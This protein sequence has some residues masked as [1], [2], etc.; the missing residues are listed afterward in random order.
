LRPVE[1]DDW[2]AFYAWDQDDEAS[3][4]A[5]RIDFPRSRAA[6]R[7]WAEQAATERPSGNAFRW[8]IIDADGAFAGSINTHT[9]D[10]RVGSFGIGIGV[11]PRAQG[12]CHA[13]EAIRLVL[14]RYMRQV[15]ARPWQATA[16]LLQP[17]L[18]NIFVFYVPPIAIAHLLGLLATNHEPSWNEL[19][20]PVLLLAG[21]W[22]GGEALWRI[23][24]YIISRF[25]C[26]GIAALQ[27]EAMDELY[28]KDVGF[29]HNNF[30]NLRRSKRSNNKLCRVS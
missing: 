12:Q 14:R 28:E 17:G 19:A 6:V 24:H 30:A 22:L 4:M 2:P 25:E 3:R 11:V 8:V 15:R 7:Q 16:S 10:P 18:G 9:C 29:F 21:A 1:P 20:M 5:E 27:I 23:G 13:A 26:A